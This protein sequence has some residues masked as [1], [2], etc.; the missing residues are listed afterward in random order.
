LLANWVDAPAEVNG[1]GQA[2]R[3]RFRTE[4]QVEDLDT[5]EIWQGL[6]PIRRIPF[7]PPH[8]PRFYTLR[9]KGASAWID[10]HTA[11]IIVVLLQGLFPY[12][13]IEA[14]GD[15]PEEEATRLLEMELYCPL[16]GGHYFPHRVE[17][18]APGA[19]HAG[20]RKDNMVEARRYILG[21]KQDVVMKPHALAEEEGVG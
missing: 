15:R 3:P 20:G 13:H 18:A 12:D 16:A 8:H 14:G 6:V 17:E 5:I 7:E 21:S 10:W 4:F 1:M 2:R 11:Q 19:N 9:A